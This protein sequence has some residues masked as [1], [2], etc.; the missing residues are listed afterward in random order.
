MKLLRFQ[1]LLSELLSI[2][3]SFRVHNSLK[4]HVF[5]LVVFVHNVQPNWGKLDPKAFKCVFFGYFSTK[6]G[7]EVLYPLAKRFLISCDVTFIEDQ[8]FYSQVSL[9]GENDT[10]GD[11]L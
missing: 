8:T 5:G 4:P 11:K 3:P 1:T 9:Q 7:N 2:F 6:K 10:Q